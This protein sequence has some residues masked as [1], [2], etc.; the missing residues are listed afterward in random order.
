MASLCQELFQH[1]RDLAD[2]GMFIVADDLG[3]LKSF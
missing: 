1:S 2:S 3:Y